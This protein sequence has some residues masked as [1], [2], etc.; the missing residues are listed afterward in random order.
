M[1]GRPGRA[2]LR[3]SGAR[4]LL[5]GA[6]RVGL[7]GR[8]HPGVG[9]ASC[10]LILQVFRLVIVQHFPLLVDSLPPFKD[11]VHGGSLVDDEAWTAGRREKQRRVRDSSSLPGETSLPLFISEYRHRVSQIYIGLICSFQTYLSALGH[12]ATILT[13][14]GSASLWEHVEGRHTEGA[15]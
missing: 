3:A 13:F 1:A 14:L 15:K 12:T 7:G 2:F 5:S 6:G 10:L 11:A 8:G 4:S 9:P